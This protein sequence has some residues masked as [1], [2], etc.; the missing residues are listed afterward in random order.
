MTIPAFVWAMDAGRER[1]LKPADRLVLIVLADR[2]NG[3]RICWP[4][5]AQLMVD[6]GLVK[7]TVLAAVHR[8]ADLG[9][10]R[11]QKRPK[12]QEYHILRPEEPVQNSTRSGNGTGAKKHPISVQNSTRSTASNGA[13]KH[14]I[15]P[16]GPVQNSTPPVQNSTPIGAKEHHKTLRETERNTRARESGVASALPPDGAA[17]TP[18]HEPP[19]TAIDTSSFDAWLDQIATKSKATVPLA[20]PQPEVVAADVPP[21]DTP[22]GPVAA[23]S[24]IRGI[25]HAWRSRPPPTSSLARFEQIDARRADPASKANHPP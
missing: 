19:A 1:N 7:R 9:L 4:S 16:S 20:A 22:V 3:R 14:P 8:L 10:I 5:I 25:A 12:G 18:P 2:G 6:T 21:D 23:D 11:I 17:A 15:G 24:V 13:K